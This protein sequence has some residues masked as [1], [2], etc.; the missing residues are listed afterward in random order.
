M[1]TGGE[2]EGEGVLDVDRRPAS[3]LPYGRRCGSFSGHTNL[4]YHGIP[5]QPGQES[6][7]RRGEGILDVDRRRACLL[8]YG[9]QCA[10]FSGHTNHLYHGIPKQPG[11]ESGQQQL[12]IRSA[13]QSSERL[14]KDSRKE[15]TSVTLALCDLILARS[16]H[17]SHARPQDKAMA[18]V[19]RIMHCT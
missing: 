8:P 5:K 15:K 12:A 11:Q 1:D 17:G 7:E 2:G 3:L 14:S 19:A 9:R 13:D 10:S 6:G 16:D 18:S 4:L